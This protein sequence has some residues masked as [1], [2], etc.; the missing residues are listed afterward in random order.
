MDF[1]PTISAPQSARLLLVQPDTSAALSFIPLFDDRYLKV[2]YELSTSHQHAVRKL[3]RSPAPYHM[4][5]CD[6]QLADTHNL[7]L[8]THNRTFHPSVPFIVTAR[9]AEHR[10][11]RRALE[12][13]A[14][15]FI[16]APL[17]QEQAVKTIRRALW[18]NW[19]RKLIAQKETTTAKYREH[20]A[21]GYPHDQR[22]EDAYRRACEIVETS[23]AIMERSGVWVEETGSS[24]SDIATGLEI[25]TRTQALI[26]LDA[27]H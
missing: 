1:S 14:I 6:A 16:Q 25:Q 3:F 17:E 13:G 24:L 27:S 19:L 15:D 21:K 8:L 10:S 7:L 9:E 22:M 20:L 18:H 4:V 26:R 12:E 11:V 2:E 23:L 5:V